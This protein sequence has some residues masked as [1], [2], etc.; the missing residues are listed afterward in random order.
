M[1]GDRAYVSLHRF[2]EGRPRHT[3]FQSLSTLAIPPA[4]QYD[5]WRE[6]VIRG[7][8]L[9][10][11]SPFQRQGFKAEVTSLATASGELHYAQSDGFRAHRSPARVRADGDDELALFFIRSGRLLM[12]Q[13]GDQDLHALPGDFF[14]YDA[15]RASELFVEPAHLVQI[16]LSREAMTARFGGVPPASRVA[17]ALRLSKLTPL[18]STQLIL[19]PQ[20]LDSLTDPERV[21]ALDATTALATEVLQGALSHQPGGRLFEESRL[22]SGPQTGGLFLAACRYIEAKLTHPN[23]DAAMVAQA[24]GCSRSTLYRSFARNGCAVSDYIRAT[25]LKRLRSLLESAP[26]TVPIGELAA[27]CGL[28]DTPNVSRLFRAAFAITPSEARRSAAERRTP[29]GT[30]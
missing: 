19:L 21:A 25:R 9:P 7:A 14:L 4:Q 22:A 23:L 27:R 29:R 10:R 1:E 13:E 5:Y 30:R 17:Q 26:S 3:V 11:P 6:M 15:G 28:Y 20:L 12:R 2:S 16:D 18:L 24:L 8:D